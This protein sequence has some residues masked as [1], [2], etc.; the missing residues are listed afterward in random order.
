MV[1]YFMKVGIFTDSYLPYVS[2]VVKSI[3]FFRQ[4]YQK[5]GHEV[6]IF[7]PHYA[8]CTKEPRIFRYASVPSL[9]NPGYNLAIPFSVRVHPL[10]KNL[11]L[12]II[13]VHSP[14][15]LGRVGARYARKHRIPLV[16]TFHTLYEKYVHYFPWKQKT[17]RELTRRICRNF[18]NSCDLVISPTQIVADYLIDLGVNSPIETIPTGI[19]LAPF[20]EPNLHWLRNTYR[21]SPEKKILIFVG[22]LGQEKNIPFL[23]KILQKLLPV[24]PELCLVLV[25]DGPEKENFVQQIHQMGLEKQIILTG[26]LPWEKVVNCYQ[27]SDIFVC[28]SL[29]ETQGLV[30]VEAKAAGKPAVAV[31]S[32]GVGEMI[33][34]QEDGFLT[35]LDEND[36]V[37]K[38][39]L[40][41]DNPQLYQ[42]MSLKALQNSLKFSAEASTKK[43]LGCY[44]KLIKK[45]F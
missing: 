35:E 38:I 12:D 29:T 31:R 43:M 11:H 32:Y 37:Q 23:F 45:S 1:E 41:L 18:C 44:Q 5:Q 28:S 16:V 22:R 13:H 15:L 10:L 33:A 24:Y 17:T 19:E 14:F 2:G 4:E 27:D 42:Q 30:V 8:K 6:Y 40:L 9:A 39:K 3:E 26:K 21:L 20:R 34:D 36:F 7:A 25:G